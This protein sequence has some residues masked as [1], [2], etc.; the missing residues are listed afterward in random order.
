M[1]AADDCEQNSDKNDFKAIFPEKDD[2]VTL[3]M[4]TCMVIQHWDFH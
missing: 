1:H 3:T 4:D 2:T